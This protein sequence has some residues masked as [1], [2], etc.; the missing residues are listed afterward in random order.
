MGHGHRRPDSRPDGQDRSSGGAG[1]WAPPDKDVD[2]VCHMT[3]D[4]DIAKTAVYEGH[5]YHFCSQDCRGKFEENP[6]AYLKPT[7][8]AQTAKEHRHAC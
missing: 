6:R 1:G 7:T 2:P 5:V 8:E 4:T 3:V